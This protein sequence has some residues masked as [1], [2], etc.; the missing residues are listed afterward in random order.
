VDHPTPPAPDPDDDVGYEVLAHGGEHDEVDAVDP[1]DGPGGPDLSELGPWWQ[2]PAGV[3]MGER[4]HL[5][6]DGRPR[7]IERR[8]TVTED[9]V[10]HRLDHYLKRMIPRLSRTRVQAA[11]ASQVVQGAGRPLRA[12][13][14]VALGEEYV[15]RRPARAEPPCPRTFTVLHRDDEAMVVDKPAGL[16]VHASAKFYFNTLT[17]VVDERF[18]GEGWQICHRLDRETSGTLVLARGRTAAAALKGAFEGKKAEKI[19]L[20]IVHGDPPWP[21]PAA[22]GAGAALDQPPDLEGGEEHTLAHPLRLARAGDPSLLPGVR[23]LVDPDGADALPSITRVRVLARVPGYA[24]V[25]CRLITG[26]QHQ[27]RAHVAHAGFPIVGDK[28]YGHG[29]RVFMA[30][31]DRGLTR[32]LA[33]RFDLPRHALHAARIRLPHPSG[34]L[35]DVSAPLAWDLAAFLAARARRTPPA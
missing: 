33:L 32:E 3:D 2:P 9:H 24:L 5:D 6:A 14:A 30:F 13:T 10:G 15:L 23:M 7:V 34:S 21:G 4:A 18:P 25:R 35:L 31:C 22:A 8:F 27:I 20:A 12:S 29:E 26:R 1:A 17:R 28:L 16:P 11:I 19:Y